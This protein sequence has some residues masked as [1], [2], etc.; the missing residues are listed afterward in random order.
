MKHSKS[1]QLVIDMFADDF[2]FFGR[3]TCTA[4][5]VNRLFQISI[6]RCLVKEMRGGMVVNTI[7]IPQNPDRFMGKFKSAK[8]LSDDELQFVF[9]YYREFSLLYSGEIKNIVR[10]LHYSVVNDEEWLN[11]VD[12]YGRPKK[13]MKTSNIEVL[14]QLVK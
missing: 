7:G 2:G 4:M 5:E 1:E 11:N 13:L 14:N 8:G 9:A 12:N 6:G 3:T 10:L